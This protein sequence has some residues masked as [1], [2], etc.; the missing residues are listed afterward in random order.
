MFYFSLF[1]NV[2]GKV[3]NVITDEIE[4]ERKKKI[5]NFCIGFTIL[6]IWYDLYTYE[7]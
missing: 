4:L 6:F 7:S 5:V 1:T 2:V 3:I